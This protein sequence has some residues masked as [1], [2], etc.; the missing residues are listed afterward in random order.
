M[1]DVYMMKIGV[2]SDTHI[3]RRGYRLLDEV[4]FG[5]QGVELILHAGDIVEDVVL[6]DL[7]RI[8]P[9]HAVAGNMDPITLV[10]R[11]GRK[12]LIHVCGLRIGL[13]HGDGVR[14]STLL[15]ALNSFP[16][17]DC[18]VF[19]HTHKPYNQRHGRVLMFNPGSP[20]D[21]KRPYVEIKR[22]S[23]GILSIDKG[24]IEG[25]VVYV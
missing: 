24:T 17:A 5:L 20:T 9:V 18:I 7:E 3:G 10:H 6:E 25:E 23:F 19:G 4:R 1:G 8:A 14:T 22:A 12:K 16:E 21:F 11:L 13:V 2:I 15:R